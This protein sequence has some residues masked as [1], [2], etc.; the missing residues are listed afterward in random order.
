MKHCYGLSEPNSLSL[1]RDAADFV[2][3]SNIDESIL[4]SYECV[5]GDNKSTFY[6]ESSINQ[7]NRQVYTNIRSAIDTRGAWGVLDVI[8]SNVGN[9]GC[10]EIQEILSTD[11][12]ASLIV[13]PKGLS[14]YRDFNG[15]YRA[16]SSSVG[17]FNLNCANN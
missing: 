4:S 13:K 2:I 9:I 17:A 12:R 10:N 3:N 1:Q 7:L 16:P 6:N 5:T 15:N 11:K 14:V 8:K